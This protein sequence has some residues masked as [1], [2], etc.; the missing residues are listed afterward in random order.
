ALLLPVRKL[1]PET[2]GLI[3]IQCLPDEESNGLSTSVLDVPLL[4]MRVCRRWSNIA[5]STPQ[6]WTTF[7]DCILQWS[8]QFLPMWLK[9]SGCLPV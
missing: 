1:P 4:L 9:N 8:Q 6:L 2:L 7:H 3:F 5:R